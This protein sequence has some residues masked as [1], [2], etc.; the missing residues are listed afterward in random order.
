SGMMKSLVDDKGRAKKL[1]DYALPLAQKK[2]LSYNAAL[3]LGLLAA[4]MKNMKTSETFF[5]VCMDKAAKLQSF[6]KL[7]QAYGLPIELH[8]GYKNYVDSARLS[9]ELLELNTDDG[10]NRLVIATMKNRFD[11]IEFREPQEGFDT[12]ER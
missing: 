3:I 5:R 8:Y 4:D 11:E 10:K 9:K 12:A 7:K 1:L 6:E 2:E